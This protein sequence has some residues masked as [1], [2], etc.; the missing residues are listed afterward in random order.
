MAAWQT[1]SHSYGVGYVDSSKAHRAADQRVA[2][3]TA[4]D[5]GYHSAANE[6]SRYER[7]MIRALQDEAYSS[8][9]RCP[10]PDMLRR[11]PNRERLL[12]GY[13]P[14]RTQRPGS[15]RSRRSA[16]SRRSDQSRKSQG[17]QRS[18]AASRA[19]SSIAASTAS[20]GPAP[21]FVRQVQYPVHALSTSTTNSLYGAGGHMPNEP[22]P[23]RESW[24][25][26]R[27]GGQISSYDNCLVN[28]AAQVP[29]A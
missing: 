17:S 5:C 4:F 23:G 9:K 25:L 12:D 8:G 15:G 26:G 13:D 16:S 20:A 3:M 14:D 10:H 24:M 11:Y 27:G 22:I 18:G 2:G 19:G 29:I 21:G 7:Q 1:T 6:F 28:K